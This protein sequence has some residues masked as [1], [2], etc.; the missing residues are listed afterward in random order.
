MK[1]LKNPAPIGKQTPVSPARDGERGAGRFKAIVWTLILASFVYVSVKVVPILFSEYQFQ[2]GIQSIA[3]YGSANRQ[4]LELISQSVLK[5]AQKDDLPLEAKDIKVEATNGNV[6]ISADYSITV[7]LHVYQW[8]LNF[9]P[10]AS[11]S[12]LF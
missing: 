6:R 3:R 4:S 12:A 7:D 8:T 9:H 5:E 1:P 11:N 2:D 10:A